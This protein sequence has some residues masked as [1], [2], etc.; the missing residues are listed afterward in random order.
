MLGLLISIA[1]NAAALI[2]VTDGCDSDP[3]QITPSLPLPGTIIYPGDSVQFRDSIQVATCGNGLFFNKA[4]FYITEDKNIP[5]FDAYGRSADI[6]ASDS[7][8]TKGG[9]L[10]C[11]NAHSTTYDCSAFKWGDDVKRLDLRVINM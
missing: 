3:T 5:A 7:Y 8:C 11:F 6:C 10:S 2:E 4:N 1:G 9:C